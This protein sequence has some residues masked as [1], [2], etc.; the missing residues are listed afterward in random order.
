MTG[1]AP[2]SIALLQPSVMEQASYQLLP[3]LSQAYRH[4]N[5]PTNRGPTTHLRLI[6]Q[7]KLHSRRDKR[8]LLPPL[9]IS[10][11]QLPLRTIN[12][13]RFRHAIPFRT[14]TLILFA[15]LPLAHPPTTS[16]RS[17]ATVT[18]TFGQGTRE[19]E[20]SERRLI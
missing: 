15:H 13:I 19:R 5:A 18:G 8:D 12:P 1:R 4:T 10:L 11:G 2:P 6:P 17:I 3:I 20:G 16:Y 9:P 14:T 7:I